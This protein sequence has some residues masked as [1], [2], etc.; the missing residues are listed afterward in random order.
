ML[1]EG[2][3]RVL[4]GFDEPLSVRAR[5]DLESLG[6]EV[7][8]GAMVTRIEPDAVYVGDERLPAR[9]VFW[10]AG[11]IASPLGRMLGAPVDRAGRV[12][13]APDLSAPGHPDVF[14][15]GDLAAVVRA[16]GSL[17]PGVAPAAIQEGAQAA[18]NILRD[19]R[20]EPRLPFRYRDKGNLATIG[21][22]RAVAEFGRLRLTGAFAW[23]FW[24][25]VHILY[26]VGF[27][28]RLSVLVEWGYSYFTY[29]RGSRLI[30]GRA[31]HGGAHGAS[32]APNAP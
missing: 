31:E 6:V 9:T 30:E 4:P 26:L 28:N 23:W 16:D 14:V 7:R 29:Q 21:R 20:D 13:V 15:V 1:L 22:H 32:P 24:L 25:F 10:A 2:G 11:N 27:R 19:I 8:T 12:H 18:R 17:V 3:P 5:H